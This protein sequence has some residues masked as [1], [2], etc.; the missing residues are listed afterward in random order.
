V[1]FVTLD[2]ATIR[3]TPVSLK[4]DTSNKRFAAFEANP[5]NDLPAYNGYCAFGVSL[6]KKFNTDPTV[7][8]IVDGRLYF[9]LDG[10]IQKKWAAGK[11]ADIKT[12]DTNWQNIQ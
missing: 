12:A 9:N 11:A 5:E 1:R 8:K 2:S 10:D 4:P 3:S 7:Y 6:G